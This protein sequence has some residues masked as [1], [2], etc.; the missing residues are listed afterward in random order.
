M[1]KSEKATVIED[2]KEKFGKYDFFYLTDSSTM[3]VEQV[4]NLRRKLFENGIQMQV[5]KNKLA[6][7]ALE[8]ANQE[9]GY[10]KLFDILKGPT[11]ILFTETANAPA[12]VIK[13]LRKGKNKDKE[14][15]R[16][17]LKA[18]YIDAGI[19]V[20]DDQIDTLASLKSKEELLG[21]IIALLQSPAKNVISALK[22][23]GSTIA[24]LVKALE[25]RN[26]HRQANK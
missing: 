5:V 23:G 24:G 13:E 26:L 21:E 12:K 8:A 16:P 25:E 9:K 19:Y 15:A 6:I 2:L 11:A 20:G 7:K 22:S 17:L 18:A 1:T 14:K 10:E 4:N 3:T